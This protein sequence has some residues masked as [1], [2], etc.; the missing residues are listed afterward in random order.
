MKTT[1]QEVP[2][3]AQPEDILVDL[4][5]RGS[6]EA[7]GLL[8]EKYQER[9]RNLIYS[10]FNDA[11]LIDDIS[12][13]IFIKA[14]EA[15]STFRAESSFYTWLYRIAVNKARDEIRRKKIRRM[16]SLQTLLDTIDTEIL[17]KLSSEMR[18]NEMSELLN[19]E[20]QKLPAVFR[21]PV[22]LKDIDGLSYEE[23]ADVIQCKV[24]TVKSR[25][26]RGRAILR[27]NLKPLLEEGSL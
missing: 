25:L 4:A 6:N 22:I 17:G 5:K 3:K 14:Y 27:R 19:K 12:Q 16:L 10:I 18:T 21:I 23:I 11:S 7:F 24:G 13:D 2:L 26:S 8:V 20:I 9:I 1:P 15:I